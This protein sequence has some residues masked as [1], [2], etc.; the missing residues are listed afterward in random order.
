MPTTLLVPNIRTQN[1]KAQTNFSHVVKTI[2]MLTLLG[3]KKATGKTLLKDNVRDL[4][5]DLVDLE[6][7]AFG[8]I[9][10]KQ[11]KITQKK[12]VITPQPTKGQNYHQLNSTK[13]GGLMHPR[14]KISSG[15]TGQ[16]E[17]ESPTSDVSGRNGSR[18]R[19]LINGKPQLSFKLQG[20]T[21]SR[22]AATT[23][24]GNENTNSSGH[25]NSGH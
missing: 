9:R 5:S 3:Q 23:H 25:S 22:T 7:E 1:A 11:V 8:V 10:E 19:I 12:L 15:F 14:A 6:A 4:N 13:G 2:M 18:G 16:R 21:S 24:M 17:T 20:T